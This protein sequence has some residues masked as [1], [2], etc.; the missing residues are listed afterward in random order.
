M[1]RTKP[2]KRPVKLSDAYF[3]LVKRHPLRSIQSELE[4]NA[5]QA[6]IDE[7]LLQELDAS[8]IT[9]L[10]ALSDLVILYERDHHPVAP[11]PQHELLAYLL[12]ER[13]MSQ[14]DLVR[15]TGIAKATVSDLASGK[16]PFTVDHMHRIAA[17]VGLP[18]TAFMPRVGP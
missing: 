4:L 2:R 11:L 15:K 13:A 7:L 17:V 9:Y 5:A 1:T 14:A 16:R 6:V 18:P 8:S 12:E 3:D 10:D